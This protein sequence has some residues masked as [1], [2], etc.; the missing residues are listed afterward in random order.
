MQLKYNHIFTAPKL[1][2]SRDVSGPGG[3]TLELGSVAMDATTLVPARL[4]PGERSCPGLTREL[5]GRLS[6]AGDAS[7]SRVGVL[8]VAPSAAS[9]R[10]QL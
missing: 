7:H 2:G 4:S 8:F 5:A 9:R 10:A 1:N 6:A 3:R